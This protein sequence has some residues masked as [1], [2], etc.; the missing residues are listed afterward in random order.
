[1]TMPNIEVMPTGVPGLDTVLGGGLPIGS[2]NV[3]RGGP[4][5]GKTTLAHQILFASATT[6]RPGLFCTLVGEPPVKMLRYQQQFSFF[7]VG[8]VGS[9]IHYM[10]LHDEVLDGDL[11]RMFDALVREVER[12]EPAFVVVDSFSSVTRQSR[13]ERGPPSPRL[14][15]FLQRLS[16][17]MTRWEATSFLLGEFRGEETPDDP[18]F[19]IA[20]GVL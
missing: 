1:M 13:L 3:V 9:A 17:A 11:D 8:K 15:S 14:Q 19:T 2:F 16:N 12:L 4:G 18:I 6:E 10:N 5:A 20:D 7:D